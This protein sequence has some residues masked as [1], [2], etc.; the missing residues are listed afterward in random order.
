MGEF[1]MRPVFLVLLCATAY[2]SATLAMKAASDAPGVLAVIVIACCLAA[3]VVGEVML[4]QRTHLSLAHVAVIAGETLI[5]L[6][7]AAFW[8]DGLGPREWLG[9]AIVLAGVVVIST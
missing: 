1:L 4:I 2:A 7:V 8:G 5:V 6:T 3:A 9:A